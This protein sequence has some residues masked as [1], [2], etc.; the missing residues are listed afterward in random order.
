M[1]RDSFFGCYI[2][3]W[4]VVGFL[5]F[6]YTYIF[7]TV[8]IFV[9]IWTL[10]PRQWTFPALFHSSPPGSFALWMELLPRL[11]R[12]SCIGSLEKTGSLSYADLPNVD[13]FYYTIYIFKIIVINHLEFDKAIFSPWFK[14]K[15]YS[16]SVLFGR[17]GGYFEDLFK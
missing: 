11:D 14:R 15:S 17:V 3:I 6:I 16:V 9:T 5:S 7:S 13:L 2:T 4:Q 10:K 1:I 8:H 12:A